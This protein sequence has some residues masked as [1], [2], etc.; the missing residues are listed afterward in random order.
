MAN[1]DTELLHSD[2]S[3]Q[4]LTW[5]ERNGVTDD[6]IVQDLLQ[7]FEA[8]ENLNIW[9]TMDPFEYLPQPAP[10]QGAKLLNWA[11]TTANIRNVMVFLPV[12]LTWEAVSKAT[13]A[14][15]KFVEA[16]NATTVNFLEFWQN[17]YDVLPSFWTIS[18]IA[19]LDFLIILGVIAL[20]LI[21]TFLNGKGSSK[22]KAELHEIEKDRLGIA[23]ALKMYLYAMR[24]IDKSNIKEGVASSVSALLTA[25]SSLS[26][27]ARQLS[28][29]V[30]EL[31]SGV[32][33]INNFGTKLGKESEKLVLEVG[34]LTAA[35]SGINSSITGELRDAVES[36]T[37]GLDLAN[38]ELNTSTHSIRTNT[39]AAESE[40]KTLQSLIK[41]A[42]RGK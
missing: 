3:E 31:Q 27:S 39:K 30:A 26:K 35:L 6:R 19:S 42:S 5:A 33:V 25:T 15:A 12:A 17:G 21:A 18:H 24:E 36:A 20:S 11:K 40:I 14:F 13:E 8:E 29:V 16:N 4:L 23:L 10:V 22:N 7:D 28:A 38:T 34:S 1:I 9:A 32:P 2:I 37:Y 41:K